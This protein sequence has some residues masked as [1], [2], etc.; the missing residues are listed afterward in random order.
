MCIQ[1]LAGSSPGSPCPPKTTISLP[2]RVAVWL[3]LHCHKCQQPSVP[4]HYANTEVFDRKRACTTW[5]TCLNKC[6]GC[7][8]TISVICHLPW[9]WWSAVDR[10]KCPVIRLKV[11]LV[12]L[13]QTQVVS[14]F[15]LFAVQQNNA[16]F[17]CKPNLIEFVT[18]ICASKGVQARSSTSGCKGHCCISRKLAAGRIA[19]GAV[20]HLL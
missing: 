12:K 11:K 16:S 17:W 6:C 15:L 14:N 18:S 20:T 5:Y 9:H 3:S 1:T 19:V 4:L 2:T 13:Q 8:P 10:W 7:F